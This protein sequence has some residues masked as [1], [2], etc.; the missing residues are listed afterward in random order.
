[1][2]AVPYAR[3]MGTHRGNEHVE[4]SMLGT[5][6]CLAGGHFVDAGVGEQ[7]FVDHGGVQPVGQQHAVLLDME[8]D[9]VEFGDGDVVGGGESLL[10]RAAKLPDAERNGVPDDGRK[11]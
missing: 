11:R 1:M 2:P 7:R 5:V 6:G 8:W 4:G 9:V 10:G 3:T